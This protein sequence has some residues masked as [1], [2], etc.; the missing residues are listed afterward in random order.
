MKNIRPMKSGPVTTSM[1]TGNWT[2]PTGGAGTAPGAH[3]PSAS[4]ARGKAPRQS[5]P[6]AAMPGATA[7][8]DLVLTPGGYRHRSLVHRIEAGHAVRASAGRLQKV[9]NS[10]R[11]VADL[12]PLHTRLD[13]DPLMPKNVSRFPGKKPALG[14][15]WIVYADWSNA[16]GNAITSFETSW[17]VPPEPT[18]QSGQTIF[19]FNG[20]Q[21]STM[22]YQ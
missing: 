16:T 10:G 21:N 14:S 8:Q 20:I 13:R 5:M 2:V 19:L 3:H 22:I 12:G 6:A 1:P 9:H 15:G 18:T 7:A 17:T 11:V 4:A